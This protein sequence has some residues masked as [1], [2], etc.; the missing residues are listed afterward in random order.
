MSGEVFKCMKIKKEKNLLIYATSLRNNV[1]REILKTMNGSE[2]KF[3]TK[4]VIDIWC[5]K[6]KK[7]IGM[8]SKCFFYLIENKKKFL[9]EF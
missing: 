8:E 6:N 7:Y 1:P 4:P 3:K 9:L 5:R 2:R